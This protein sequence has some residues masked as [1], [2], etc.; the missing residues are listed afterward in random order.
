MDSEIRKHLIRLSGLVAERTALLAPIQ[1]KIDAEI[2]ALAETERRI[3]AE[4]P[5]VYADYIQSPE[6]REKAD[7]AK[8]RAGHKCQLCGDGHLPLVAHHN[9]YERLGEERDEDVFVLCVGCNH[10]FHEP[11]EQ[12]RPTRMPLRR[13]A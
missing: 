11:N 12:G 9:T 4:K 8:V 5:I 2:L 1:A 3:L 10:K 6:W 7:A 13:R